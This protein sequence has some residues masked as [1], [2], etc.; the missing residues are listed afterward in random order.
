MSILQAIRIFLLPAAGHQFAAVV[1][2]EL[3]RCTVL[4]VRQALSVHQRVLVPPRCSWCVR[5]S[6][7]ITRSPVPRTPKVPCVILS[8]HQ[9]TW[10][11]FFLS[12][13]FAAEPGAQA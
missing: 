4:A 12:A 7:S 5:S 10:E 6:A 3:L 1:L 2:A 8:N 9:S 13:Y 11:T